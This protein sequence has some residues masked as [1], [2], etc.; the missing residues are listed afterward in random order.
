MRMHYIFFLVLRCCN[1]GNRFLKEALLMGKIL[2]AYLMPHPPIIIKEIGKGEERKINETI[3]SMEY[4]AEDVRQKR[5]DTIIV[6]TPHGPVFR[7]AVAVSYEAYLSGT[8]KKFNA[9]DVFIGK[10]NN[11]VLV[12]EIVRRAGQRSIVS[13]KI[14]DLTVRQYDLEK[15]L[16]HGAIVPLYF[17]EK[18]YKDYELIH[19][20]Y[21]MLSCEDLYSFGK[22]I[23]EAV[24]GGDYN[25]SIIASGDLSHRLSDDGPYGYHPSGPEFDAKLLD[26]IRK[27][28]YRDIVRFDSKESESAGE[29]GLRSIDILLGTLDGIENQPEV[30]SYQKPFG[31]GYGVAVFN[32]ACNQEQ[33]NE[34]IVESL[35]DERRKYLDKKRDK[36]DAYVRLARMSLENDVLGKNQLPCPKEYPE[37]L[38]ER[39]AGVFVSLKINGQLRGCIG[40]ISPTKGTLFD[41]IMDNALKAGLNDPRFLPVDKDELNEIEYS[42]DILEKPEKVDS[43]ESL[44]PVE[45]GVI[46][47]KGIRRGLLLPNLDGIDSPEKQIGIALKKANINPEEDYEISRFRVTRHY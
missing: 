17:I 13:V 24:A 15:D 3:K 31:I 5:P 33:E 30:L 22:A 20:T 21:G 9:E 6:I 46:V 18:K 39:K 2:S 38:I 41:E 23:Q 32:I 7:D 25:V 45:Y 47:E 16:D 4:I 8:L 14:D 42:V 34:S 10:N 26:L 37:E 12:D 44:N 40:T 29:C 28:N 43:K 11:K 19:I 27:K 36:E 1:E 35:Y